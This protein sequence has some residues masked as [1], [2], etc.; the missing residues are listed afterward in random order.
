MSRTSGFRRSISSTRTP[1]RRLLTDER[2]HRH[3]VTSGHVATVLLQHDQTVAGDHRREDAG[4]LRPRRADFPSAVGV[5]ED[6]ALELPPSR[7]L[8]HRLHRARLPGLREEAAAAGP[9]ERSLPPE[10]QER[11]RASQL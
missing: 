7:L 8:A 11:Q 3:R 1:A 9:L 4:A 2:L 5:L 6:A 10:E